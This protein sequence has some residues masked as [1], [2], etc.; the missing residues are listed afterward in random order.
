MLTTRWRALLLAVIASLAL[1]SLA[2]ANGTDLLPAGACGPNEIADL[3]DAGGVDV[4]GLLW[5]GCYGIDPSTGETVFIWAYQDPSQ[6]G[7]EYMD[8]L[9]ASVA[10]GVSFFTPVTLAGRTVVSYGPP[11]GAETYYFFNIGDTVYWIQATTQAEAERAVQRIGSGGGGGGGG[12]SFTQTVPDPTTISVDPIVIATSVAAAAGIAVAAPFPSALFN[13]TLEANYDEVSGWFRRFRRRVSGAG[14]ALGARFGDFFA[15]RRGLA[16]FIGIAA[17]MYGFLN[18]GFGFNLESGAIVIGSWFGIVALIAVDQFPARVYTRR[19]L[20]E[21]GQLRIHTAGLLIGL[22]CVVVTRITDFQPGY[23][24]GVVVAYTFTR[25]LNPIQAG[26]ASALAAVSSL[27]LAFSAFLALGAVRAPFD[28]SPPLW[29][30]PVVAALV[31]MVIGGI[32]DV[33][34]GLLPMRYMPGREIMAWSKP[35]WVV[36]FGASAF[37]FLHVLVN[38]SSGYLADT[39]LQPLGKVIALF[40]GFGLVSVLFWAFFRYRKPRTDP[41][42]AAML[43]PATPEHEEPDR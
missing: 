20:G 29:A 7:Q 26:K 11:G 13:S 40:V 19:R 36:L 6:S 1:T 24:Y 37:A 12:A 25:A 33:L 38:P 31:V 43:Q 3:G 9:T 18:P 42:A 16:A 14:S 15:T 22:G 27:A 21:P 32:E 23:L 41:P 30:L 5:D 34:F 39:T 4:E 28:G 35:V 8:D 10:G 17:V 2:L